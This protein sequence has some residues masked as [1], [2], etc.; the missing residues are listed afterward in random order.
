[1]KREA[2]FQQNFK[3]I[4]IFTHL[5]HVTRVSAIKCRIPFLFISTVGRMIYQ[6]TKI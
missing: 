5:R 2:N 3:N 6:P 4:E 1:M